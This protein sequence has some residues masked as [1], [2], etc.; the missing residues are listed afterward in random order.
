MTADIAR[1]QPTT[2]I[3]PAPFSTGGNLIREAAA[4][5]ADAHMLAKA[6]CNTQMVPAHFKGKP[7]ECAAA[8]LYGASLG[9]DPMQA[10][11]GIYVVHGSAALY[12]RTM[13]SIVLRDGHELRTVSSTNDA[14]TVTGRRRGSDHEETSTWTYERAQLAGYTSNA[15]YKTDPQAMLYAKAVSEVCRK[16]APDSLAGVYAVEELQLERVRPDS[17][18]RRAVSAATFT[19]ISAPPKPEAPT[20]PVVEDTPDGPVDT[21]TGEVQPEQPTAGQDTP[22]PNAPTPDAIKAM[23]AGFT[24][25]GFASDARTSEGRRDRLAYMSQILQRPI[26]ATKDLTADDVERVTDALAA[27]A[28]ELAAQ[29]EK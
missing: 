16:I 5:M 1:Y 18:D 9:L 6:I 12:A 24:A 17:E 26:D 13:A 28:A 2:D 25:A 10:V 20:A 3:A 23:F 29:D 11:K 4:V 21:T 22:D 7:D 8:M 15:K 14:V 27:D 19:S